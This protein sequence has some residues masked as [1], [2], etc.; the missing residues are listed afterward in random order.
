[1]DLKKLDEFLN[2][3]EGK[4]SLT[5][6]VN[7][8]NRKDARINNQL[9]RFHDKYNFSEFVNKVIT[10]YDGD[11]YKDRWYN[12]SIE[13]PEDLYWFLFSYVRRYGRECT[14]DEWETHANMF[15]SELYYHDGYYFNKMDGQG[16]VIQITKH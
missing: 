12:R 16:S 7:K 14:V 8:L 4:K 6:Y 3:E 10:K 13:P 2:S 1:M 9:E 15:T 11:A 5:D